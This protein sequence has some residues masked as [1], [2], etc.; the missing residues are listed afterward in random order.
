MTFFILISTR[1]HHTAALL[2]SAASVLYIALLGKKVLF[3]LS[4]HFL[5][6]NILPTTLNGKKKKN[7]EITD[8]IF[9]IIPLVYLYHVSDLCLV[10]FSFPHTL[11]N[12]VLY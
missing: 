6:E 7:R 8:G 11:P 1:N 5:K 12:Y 4:E 10:S 9:S 2:L 3:L